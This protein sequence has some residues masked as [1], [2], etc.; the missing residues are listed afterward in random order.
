MNARRYFNSTTVT[1]VVTV[2]AMLFAI[3]C[4]PSQQQA[5]SAP[6]TFTR[7]PALKKY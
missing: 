4:Q 1:L 7:H 3:A 6:A 2:L 5:T